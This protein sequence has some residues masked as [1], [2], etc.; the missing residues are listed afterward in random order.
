MPAWA[1][2]RAIALLTCLACALLGAATTPAS[3]Q[4]T[5]DPAVLRIGG[6]TRFETAALLAARAAPSGAEVVVVASGEA[7]PDALGGGPAAVAQGAPLLTVPADGTLPDATARELARLAP[8]QVVLLGGTAAVSAGMAD[9]VAAAAGVPAVERLAGATRTET[10]AAAAERFFPEPVDAVVLVSG[11]D[12]PD[13]LSG[14][15]AAA[16]LDGPLLLTAADAV[17]AATL[18]QLQRLAPSTIHVVGGSAVISDAAL[19]GLDGLDATIVRHAGAS[20]VETAAVVADA[21]FDP[22]AV[23]E[24]Y[25]ATGASFADA[26]A[27][28]PPAGLAGAPILLV[29]DSAAPLSDA[30]TSLAPSTVVVVGGE[31]AVSPTVTDE[32]AAIL[33]D[34]PQAPAEEPTEEP[35]DQPTPGP[36]DAPGG[37]GGSGPP[38]PPPAPGDPEVPFDV[39]DGHARVGD[40]IE[41]PLDVTAGT[42]TVTATL[43]RP[44]PG[45]DADD[46]VALVDLPGGPELPDPA[47][48]Q[49]VPVTDDGNGTVTLAVTPGAAESL[50]GGR[51]RVALLDAGPHQL[52]LRGA[53]R[54]LGEPMD[55]TI[56][57][58][59]AQVGELPIRD[60]EIIAATTDGQT[61][62]VTYRQREIWQVDLSDPANP[63]QV[64]A[65]STLRD[66]TSVALTTDDQHLLVA[67]DD[68]ILQVFDTA[69]LTEQAQLQLAPYGLDAVTVSPDGTYAAVAVEAENADAPEDEPVQ[70]A[71][72]EITDDAPADWPVRGVAIDRSD[73]A[74][75]PPADPEA[76]LDLEPEFVD[77]DADNVAVL[78]LQENNAIAVIDLPT[79]EVRSL[80]SAGT[81]TRAFD[82]TQDEQ[83]DYS[84]VDTLARE[85][86][87]V[88]WTP[89]GHIL[90][91][92][93]GEDRGSRSW[94]L[95]T[96]EGDLV[97][98]SGLTGE[99]YLSA[100]AN[101]NDDRNDSQGMEPEGAEVA[102]VDGYGTFGFVGL[103]RAGALVVLDLTDATAPRYV[104]VV[105]TDDEPEGITFVPATG[106]VLVANENDGTFQ[107]FEMVTRATR[108]GDE[109]HL[110][111]LWSPDPIDWSHL[112]GLD[113][114]DEDVLWASMTF[115]GPALIGIRRTDAGWMVASRVDV[116]RSGAPLVGISDVVVDPD[117][118]WWVLEQADY[119]ERRLTLPA[120]IH[121]VSATGTV[122][123]T[124]PAPTGSDGQAARARG[125]TIL[126]DGRMV[127]AGLLPCCG[128][129]DLDTDGGFGLMVLDPVT[130]EWTVHPVL[131]LRSLSQGAQAMVDLA[132]S[133]RGDILLLAREDDNDL[134]G[135]ADVY[136]IRP[137][138]LVDG[139]AALFSLAVPIGDSRVEAGYQLLLNAMD[140]TPSG[141]LI[142]I[143]GAAGKREDQVDTRPFIVAD[144]DLDDTA[145]GAQVTGPLADAGVTTSPA[146][147]LQIPL[148]IDGAGGLIV[149]ASADDGA[150]WRPLPTGARQF[151]RRLAAVPVREAG[152]LTLNAWAPLAHGTYD[153]RVRTLSPGGAVGTSPV[154]TD[155]LV[156]EGD[157][158]QVQL[159]Q[160]AT[161]S[162]ARPTAGAGGEFAVD[163]LL[164][165]PSRYEVQVRPTATTQPWRTAGGAAARDGV[166]GGPDPF[167]IQLLAPLEDGVYDLRVVAS[168][169][170][171]PPAV[172]T[173]PG[174]LVV[175]TP[176][177][178]TIAVTPTAESPVVKTVLGGGLD[179][180]A[181]VLVTADQVGSWTNEIRPTGGSDDDWGAAG[182]GQVTSGDVG[183]P[184]AGTVSYDGWVDFATYDLRV[185]FTNAA[186]AVTRS[187]VLTAAISVDFIPPTMG[188]FS[189]TG[190]PR[191][192]SPG[193]PV[194]IAMGPSERLVYDVDARPAGTG[195]D[196]W[197]E[198]SSRTQTSGASYLSAEITAPSTPGRYDL[199]VRGTSSESGKP[200]SFVI[201]DMLGIGAGNGSDSLVIEAWTT[202]GP[203][204]SR[205]DFVVW[206]NPTG[207]AID[208]TGYALYYGGNSVQFAA[209]TIPDGTVL[210]P[211]ERY[212]IGGRDYAG[213][214]P[215]DLTV[216][217]DRLQDYQSV[218]IST[219]PTLTPLGET[220]L[221]ID[222]VGGD[223]GPNLVFRE[224]Q[225]LAEPA[226]DQVWVRTQ[227]TD[228]NSLDFAL[229][230]RATYLAG[231]V[232]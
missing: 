141:E 228:Q 21:L 46:V 67:T 139:Q 232:P 90:T 126:Q 89:D 223:S 119:N 135:G 53:T 33:A 65:V 163:L 185:T 172:A 19:D 188:L 60:A 73:P 78:S 178:A 125:L 116:V 153:V 34:R 106:Q 162:P 13:A 107:V 79:G 75:D 68:G 110:P 99:R 131:Q 74:L 150:T 117:G 55:L 186:G 174:S 147:E 164:S 230:D 44:A 124:I 35:T 182:G 193:Q 118:G 39:R 192:H 156:V 88:Q 219:P 202:N 27:A 104:D 201:P 210:G 4:G 59:W 50:A 91:A 94:S 196:A 121:H 191:A 154:L 29:L 130:D 175:D 155:A 122:D 82:R 69:T 85:P 95:F 200:I 54:A 64:D 51:L 20:R 102:V 144:V 189:R 195:E 71:I 86:D 58:T 37:G 103:E 42:A 24:A 160:P 142:A 159:L 203:G 127:I 221:R 187:P 105:V 179:P 48:W 123:R 10:A 16:L 134:E 128:V 211:D 70:M 45:L 43:T 11:E 52:T 183:S 137:Q 61:A 63:T 165:A 181:T 12:F 145:P 176:G 208:L 222:G 23:E 36:G 205:D 49:D 225:G 206:H 190:L 132:T 136:R 97:W 9:A 148:T 133:P 47:A 26:L 81:A 199:R 3:G 158:S 25:V 38:P 84:E 213:A 100:Y 194:S 14:G 5:Q 32:L 41:V 15:A 215:A 157:P 152:S 168:V 109:G 28:V 167:T 113:A 231:L 217:D 77:V 22:G 140:V 62:Y 149:E 80:F 1:V 184:T 76:Y 216:N 114:P 111:R 30:V 197:V 227:D 31:Q 207:E 87:T 2:T 198:V 204:G 161:A 96:P 224:N 93:E 92:D 180:D 169:P 173:A 66:A 143:N 226:A 18:T 171:G 83:L 170:D 7:F 98:T 115:D 72:V 56:T 108:E 40:F 151:V 177:A 212:L 57:P 129:F 229:V 214:R 166:L 209:T 6:A 120:A 218:A 101:I 138:D 220:R 8:E 112:I 17:P 146:G